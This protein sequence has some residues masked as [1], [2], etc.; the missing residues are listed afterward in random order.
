M[1]YPPFRVGHGYD[2]HR[3]EALY[4]AGRG[5]P[6]ILGGVRLDHD[7]GVVAHSDGDALLHAVTDGLLG[8]IGEPDI[9]QLFPDTDPRHEA[10]DS[11]VFL[12]E[13]VRRVGAAGYEV[14]NLDATVVMERPK[15]SPHKAAIRRSVATLLGIDASRVNVKGRTH[16][17]ADAIGQGLAFEVHVVVLL[18][19]RPEPRSTEAT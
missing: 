4:P 9:G 11:G 1:R 17:K 3:L 15:I 7:V 18:M 2:I 14:V 6:L 10:Q 8:A 16:E 12:K 13:A 19:H 5:R